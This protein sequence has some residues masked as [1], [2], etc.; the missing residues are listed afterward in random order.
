[1][2]LKHSQD[3]GINDLVRNKCIDEK[4]VVRKATLLLITKLVALVNGSLDD[5]IL[6]TM[7][8]AMVHAEN[9]DAVFEGQKRMINLSTNDPEGHAL[10]RSPLLEGEAIA[11]ANGAIR[12]AH[13]V[14]TPLYVVHVMRIKAMEEIAKAQKSGQR[15]ISERQRVI[16]E[17]VVSGLI[18]KDSV[19]WDPDF[20][21]AS[22]Y[23]MSPPIRAAGHDKALQDAFYVG[24]LQLVGTD[25]CYLTPHKRVL[26]LM[27]SVNYPVCQWTRGK[28]A[29]RLGHNGGIWVNVKC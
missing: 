25:H 6:K 23:V 3:S 18:L 26:G 12:L 20:T 29:F 17:P 11:Q 13:F 16:G 27:I 5:K 22:K 19:L 14:N 21:F 8:M 1:M 28:D 15:V 7:G 4:A 10:L 9:G 24:V 2:G